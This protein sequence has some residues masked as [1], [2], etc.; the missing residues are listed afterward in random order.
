[1]NSKSKW[2]LDTNRDFA[3]EIVVGT[4]GKPAHSANP[5]KGINAVYKMSKVIDAI[6]TLAPTRCAMIWNMVSMAGITL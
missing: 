5:E 3:G 6:R 4:F 1:M 2:L